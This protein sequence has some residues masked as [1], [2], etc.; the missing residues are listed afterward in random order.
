MASMFT[1]PSPSV[2]HQA[3]QLTEEEKK[4]IADVDVSEFENSGID[5]S[6]LLEEPKELKSAVKEESI[7]TVLKKIHAKRPGVDF[8]LYTIKLRNNKRKRIDDNIANAEANIQKW[9]KEKFNLGELEKDDKLVLKL[10]NEQKVSTA[11][12]RN[13]LFGGTP[14][15]NRRQ[16]KVEI[17]DYDRQQPPPSP[18]P[19][20]MSDSSLCRA[21]Q[22]LPM[23]N[24]Q[25]Q[26]PPFKYAGG[27]PLK[28]TVQDSFSKT[29]TFDVE[30]DATMKDFVEAVVESYDHDLTCSVESDLIYEGK[31]LKEGTFG[32]NN[33]KDGAVI[34]IQPSGLET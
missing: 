25:R 30:V 29:H 16:K 18:A 2:P 8:S 26:Q 31:K 27:R 13:G 11:F 15:P 24:A 22:K 3:R 32:S 17:A 21:V 33:V 12:N 4:Q 34:F 5:L 14:K 9:K 6:A 23:P 28:V 7:D 19:S 20:Q 10:Y 1:T